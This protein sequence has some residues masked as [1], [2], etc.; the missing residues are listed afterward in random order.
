MT[1]LDLESSPIGEDAPGVV[2]VVV[3]VPA[4]SRN[5]YEY[6]PKLDECFRD[7]RPTAP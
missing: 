5:K 4:G 7:L 1:N 2:N 6:E 3:E